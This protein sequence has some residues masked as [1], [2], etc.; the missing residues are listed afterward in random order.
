MSYN[1][2]GLF[3]SI[4]YLSNKWLWRMRFFALLACASRGR[5]KLF[6]SLQLGLQI[7]MSL[8]AWR[9]MKPLFLST[10]WLL[11]IIWK[12]GPLIT[13]LCRAIHQAATGVHRL[14]AAGFEFFIKPKRLGLDWE[15]KKDYLIM[16]KLELS[17][18]KH[19]TNLL[20]L[21]SKATDLFLQLKQISRLFTG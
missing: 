12:L 5:S 16:M 2:S 18:W 14:P 20:W 19:V 10:G 7:R 13:S 21:A 3:S 11:Y 9:P 15:G 1:V 4:I 8:P 17:W 6:V